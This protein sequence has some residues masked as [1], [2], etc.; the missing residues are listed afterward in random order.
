V[1]RVVTLALAGCGTVGSALLDLLERHGPAIQRRSG[2]RYDV[3]RVLVRDVRRPRRT[4]VNRALLTD[5]A[6]EFLAAPVDIVVEAIGGTT[7][8]GTLARGALQRGR[9]LVTANKALLRVEGPALAE[10]T[11][12]HR[13]AGAT[14]DFEAAVG[15]GV[16]IVRLLRDSLAGQGLHRIRGVLNGTTNF[17]LSRVERGASFTDALVAAQRAGFAEADPSRDLDGTDAADKI[18]VLAWL[19]FGV[20][21]S[22]LEV[23]TRGVC[24]TLAAEAVAA[25]RRGRAI[26]LVATAVRIG[27]GVHC[28][29]APRIVPRGHPF[30]QV[31]DEQNLIQL[32]SESTGTLTVA[33][34]GAGGSATAS[35][36]LADILRHGDSDA[37]P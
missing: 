30:A 7:A 31:R 25:A 32:E 11:R 29:V 15:G 21:P 10:L 20:D 18:A 1:S 26:R 4:P 12:R 3:S 33:G 8:A 6:E 24:E 19:G 14:L 36:I 13:A 27:D 2:V 37:T 23:R 9:R 22:T 17:I 35:A 28:T 5:D 16:P 34:A